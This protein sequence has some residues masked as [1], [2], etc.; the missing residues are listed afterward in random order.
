LVVLMCGMVEY[1]ESEGSCGSL[2]A[3]QGIRLGIYVDQSSCGFTF[4]SLKEWTKND[5][6]ITNFI[7]EP[8]YRNLNQPITIGVKLMRLRR[9]Y[10]FYILW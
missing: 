9:L 5:I 3:V 7:R 6:G 10:I 1:N 8:V 2:S 4:T